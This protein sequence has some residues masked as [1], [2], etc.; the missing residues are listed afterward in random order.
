MSRAIQ[1]LVEHLLS[2]QTLLP[3][4]HRIRLHQLLL[5]LLTFPINRGIC[6]SLKAI[7]SSMKTLDS[8]TVGSQSS[9]IRNPIE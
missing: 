3:W 2:R 1:H 8:C 4:A 9:S 5:L 6:F 7:P